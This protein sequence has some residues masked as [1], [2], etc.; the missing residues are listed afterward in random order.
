MQVSALRK[1]RGA[2]D[3][4]SRFGIF[5]IRAREIGRAGDPRGPTPRNLGAAT[6][7]RTVGSNPAGPARQAGGQ[8]DRSDPLFTSGCRRDASARRC[9]RGIHAHVRRPRTDQHAEAS[10]GHPMPTRG[11]RET[12]A[13]EAGCDRGG[14]RETDT[15][16]RLRRRFCWNASAL[17]ILRSLEPLV[18]LMHRTRCVPR[19]L[20]RTSQVGRL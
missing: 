11:V 6:N 15:V 2:G 19:L 14:P 17:P 20:T 7:Q 16:E 1:R 10:D 12:S 5:R 4:S 3:Q 9:T 13:L 18:R 8:V